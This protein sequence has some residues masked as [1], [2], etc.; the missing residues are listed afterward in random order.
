MN[1]TTIDARTMPSD[2]DREIEETLLRETRGGLS[3]PIPGTTIFCPAGRIRFFW[4]I[5]FCPGAP[6][7]GSMNADKDDSGQS[8]GISK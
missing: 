7:P 2:L 4:R 3:L 8:P 6:A 1:A 5:L